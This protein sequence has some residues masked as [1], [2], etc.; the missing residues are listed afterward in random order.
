MACGSRSAPHRGLPGRGGT[1]S[2]RSTARG[3]R[4]C[5]VR[6]PPRRGRAADTGGVPGPLPRRLAGGQCGVRR[7]GRVRPGTPA[8]QRGREPAV[9]TA[10][11]AEQLHRPQRPGRRL[12]R[13]GHGQDEAAG[14][15]PPG[16][17]HPQP[18]A[19][20]ASS[21]SWSR[22]ISRSTAAIPNAAWRSCGSCPRCA[23]GSSRLRISTFSAA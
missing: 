23:I 16:P 10:G 3:A 13:L 18:G 20:R 14:A 9:R 11:I 12:R 15:D 19:V 6:T 1:E 2:A 17:R 4:P 5:R 22:S 8:G 21:N 7:R